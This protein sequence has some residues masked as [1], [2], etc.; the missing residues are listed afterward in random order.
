M[1]RAKIPTERQRGYNWIRETVTGVCIDCA[2]V[3]PRFRWVNPQSQAER[4][5]KADKGPP[6]VPYRRCYRC[7]AGHFAAFAFLHRCSEA[8]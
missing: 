6:L 7:T 3:M 2:D 5:A 8:S 1:A 4:D